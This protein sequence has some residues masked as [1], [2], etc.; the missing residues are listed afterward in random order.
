VRRVQLP[1]H[2]AGDA[3][4]L[5]GRPGTRDVGLH[6]RARGGPVDAVELR[7]E[8]VVVEQ[9][10]GFLEDH[11]LLGG[12]IDVELRRNADRPDLSFLERDRVNAAIVEEHHLLAV[13]REAHV[14]LRA[15]RSRQL[16]GD[17]PVARELVERPRIEVLLACGAGNHDDRLAVGAD[18][19][20]AHI[21]A[22]GNER[23]PL[24]D[25]VEDDVDRFRRRFA[26]A[27]RSRGVFAGW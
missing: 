19:G 14:R 9:P 24:T 3:S 22:G 8:E 1:D 17:R 13:G 21:D 4:H 26:A 2:E 6:L 5:V 18:E 23:Q 16:P 12:E 25:V 15:S 10:P 7:I 27:G 11:R 20:L